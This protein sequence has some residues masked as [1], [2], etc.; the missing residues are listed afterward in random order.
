MSKAIEL[1]NNQHTNELT[2]AYRYLTMAYSLEQMELHGMA[3]WM[4]GQ[5]K[6]EL[7]HARRIYDYM[8]KTDLKM[9]FAP[10]QVEDDKCKTPLDIFKKGLE[11]EQGVTADIYKIMDEAIKEKHYGIQL[12]LQWFIDEQ[13]EEEEAMRGFINTLQLIGDSRSGLLALDAKM[14][15]EAGSAHTD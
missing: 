4:R 10:I 14:G 1:L 9:S 11:S 5:H 6:D 8:V 3:K 15:E 13:E 12:F 7:G 2:A